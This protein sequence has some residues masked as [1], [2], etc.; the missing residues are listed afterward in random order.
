[1]TAPGDLLTAHPNEAH[2]LYAHF[3]ETGSGIHDIAD[4]NWR[5]FFRWEDVSTILRKPAV[6]SS[7]RFWASPASIHD[8]ENP[9]HRRYVAIFEQTMLMQDPPVHTRLRG[10]VKHSFTPRALE[11]VRTAI[12]RVTRDLLA[13][14]EPGTE[15]DFMTDF[16]ESLP[17]AVI[18]EAMGIPVEDRIQFRIWSI[19]FAIPLEF[20]CTGD[21]REKALADAGDF[22][23]YLDALIAERRHNLGEDLVSQLILAEESGDRLSGDELLATISLMLVAGNETTVNLLGNGINLLLDNPD[24][25][26]DLVA[27]PDLV[28][29][30]VEEMLRME[31][32][33]RWIA[34]VTKSDV[35]LNGETVRDGTWV[36][37]SVAGANRDPRKFPDPDRFDIRRT[38]NQHLTFGGGIHFC[39]GAPLARMEAQIAL[40]LILEKFPNL[41]R[42]SARPVYTPHFNI[43]HPELLPVQL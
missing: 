19:G 15:V 35:D 10:L 28:T 33:F 3:R 12:G 11:R 13:P 25:L 36:Y 2:E 39:I 24:Q 1:M 21:A 41:S 20:S 9:V 17:V 40:P 29:S 30:A 38:Q 37:S 4:M 32:S 31:P 5:M 43:R 18:A 42:G 27:H 8:P 34:R 14:L 6:F 26:A 7:D 23:T 22:L 16:A